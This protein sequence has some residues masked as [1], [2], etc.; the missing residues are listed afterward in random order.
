VQHEEDAVAHDVEEDDELTAACAL[1]RNE[2][3]LRRSP[4]ASVP[5][6]LSL[7]DETGEEHGIRNDLAA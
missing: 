5:H 3:T 7:M 6:D 2:D 4:L 1:C